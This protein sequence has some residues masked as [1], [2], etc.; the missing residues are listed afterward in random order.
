MASLPPEVLQTLNTTCMLQAAA[1]AA[2]VM[3]ALA[4][5]MSGPAGSR[6]EKEVAVYAEAI[7]LLRLQIAKATKQAAE[8]C[9]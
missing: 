3:Q 7:A 9:R 6:S 8:D 4:P 1:N 2:T 5:Y